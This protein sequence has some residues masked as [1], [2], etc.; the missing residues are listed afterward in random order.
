MFPQNPPPQAA[1]FVFLVPQFR[2]RGDPVTCGEKRSM[3]RADKVDEPLHSFFHDTA[4][5]LSLRM[6]FFV[7]KLVA[8]SVR[9]TEAVF[10]SMCQDV[11]IFPPKTHQKGQ[12]HTKCTLRRS[13]EAGESFFGNADS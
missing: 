3:S 9:Y 2:M 7:K 6:S 12:T 4:F 11:V 10:R 8:F 5:L 1:R 13:L